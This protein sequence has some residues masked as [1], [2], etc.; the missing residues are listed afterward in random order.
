VEGQTTPLAGDTTSY[1]A[2]V[3]PPSKATRYFRYTLAIIFFAFIFVTVS[4]AMGKAIGE[5]KPAYFIIGA[6]VL[7]IA[8]VIGIQLNWMRLDKYDSLPR[9]KY[10]TVALCLAMTAL[11]S[12]LLAVVYEPAHPTY[13]IAGVAENLPQAGVELKLNDDPSFLKIF[14][15]PGYSC[16]PWS[17]PNKIQEGTQYKVD[18][19]EP[20]VGGTCT[21]S[22][23]QGT[24]KKDVTNIHVTCTLTYSV[25]GRVSGLKSNPVTVSLN[26]D[27]RGQQITQDGS[28]TFSTTLANGATWRVDVLTQPTGQTCTFAQ[29]TSG[30]IS[31]ADVTSLSLTCV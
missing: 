26:G 19:G 13:L 8:S 12:A 20:P 14:Q 22:G 11:S 23:N 4:L 28:F 3:E 27:S 17:F 6:T 5:A 16:V 18:W 1:Y 15:M 7:I 30:V 25:G 9:A 2:G 10:A 29:P 24:A 31:G 21:L